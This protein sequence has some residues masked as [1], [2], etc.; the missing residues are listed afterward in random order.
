MKQ[1][2]QNEEVKK[3]QL[4]QKQNTQKNEYYTECP[5]LQGRG[6]SKLWRQFNRGLSLFVVI[7]CGI[8]LYFILLRVDV[9]SKLF[10]MIFTVLK[11]II[12]GLAIAYLI[13]PIV[14]FVERYVRKFLERYAPNLKK[15][16]QI[17]RSVGI[18]V[19][20]IFLAAVVVAL[21]NMMIPELVRSIRSLIITLPSQ[22]NNAMEQITNMS[23]K[24]TVLG[25]TITAILEEVTDYLSTWL[26][27]D[28]LDQLN[29][30][31]SNVTVGVIGIVKELF[32]LII[33]VFVSVYLL[34]SKERFLRQCKK[35]VYAIWKPE[36]A[37]LI[38]HMVHKGNGFFGGFIIGK[39]IDSAII[40]VLCFIGL[41]FMDMPYTLLV[42]AFVGITNIIP[43]FGPYIGAIPSA[44]LIL[45]VDPKKAL[46]FIIFILIL[47]QIDGN[48][49]GPKILGDSTGLSAFWVMFAILV[50]GGL[51][52]VSGM[53]LGVPAFAM[54]YYITKML[55]E[56]Q[57]EKKKLPTDTLC[58][59]EL[60]YVTNEGQYVPSEKKMK[61]NIVEDNEKKNT[62]ESEG[63]NN[64]D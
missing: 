35:I 62:Q 37:N 8:L 28:L 50:G 19:A 36:T 52:G 38:L 61:E 40:G 4:R 14:K 58:Y 20:L 43:F 9:I 42:S 10:S 59:D 25:D 29:V 12:Y 45:L 39:I 1:E 6:P 60:S 16:Q 17:S 15:K 31:M 27:T 23:T 13:N 2:K 55:I 3:Y 7:A 18:L 53:I 26:R 56:H 24:H 64:A 51:F 22:L 41:S 33:G 5:D 46:Y 44:I 54:I 47:Q 49:I 63:K 32:N 30:V 34:G 21:V 48:L 57:L 11:P